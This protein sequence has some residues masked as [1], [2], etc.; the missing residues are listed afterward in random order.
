MQFFQAAGLK[1]KMPRTICGESR[2]RTFARFK[3]AV[4]QPSDDYLPIL[5][6]DSEDPVSD[7]DTVWQHLKKRDNWDKPNDAGDNDA[8][9]MICC[10]ET[11]F[12]ASKKTFASFFGRHYK[13]EDIPLWPDLE[14]VPRW[15]LINTLKKATKGCGPRQY[16]KSKISF[17]LLSKIDPA[18]VEGACPIGARPFLDRL[19]SL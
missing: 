5:L 1:G 6:V 9:L 11:W 16:S 3:A 7:G 2:E 10:M 18:E 15:G 12:V 13:R 4:D 8:F 14:G 19:R 17:E